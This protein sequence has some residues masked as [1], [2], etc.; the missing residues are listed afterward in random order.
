[1]AIIPTVEQARELREVYDGNPVI[2]EVE[3][4]LR[5]WFSKASVMLVLRRPLRVAKPNTIGG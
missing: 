2:D 3:I 1:M 5:Q 4:T